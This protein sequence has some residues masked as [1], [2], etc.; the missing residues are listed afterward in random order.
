MET[1]R[2]WFKIILNPLLRKIGWVIVSRVDEETDK[3][4]GYQLRKFKNN[5]II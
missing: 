2:T 4:L 1:H 3:I 5:K